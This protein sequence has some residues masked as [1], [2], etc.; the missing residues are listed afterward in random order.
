[1]ILK[2]NLKNLCPFDLKKY[3]FLKK[4]NHPSLPEFF[5]K[6]KLFSR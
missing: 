6:V 2:K 4:A 3:F 1:M 5:L